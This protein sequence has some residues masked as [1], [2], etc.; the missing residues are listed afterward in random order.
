MVNNWEKNSYQSV[1]TF[2]NDVLS[3]SDFFL[4]KKGIFKHFFEC[5]VCFF[6]NDKS[7]ICSSSNGTQLINYYK[8]DW[9]VISDSNCSFRKNN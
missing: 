7:L 1:S 6:Y 3:N 2:T 9:R 8:H 5:S 4:Q